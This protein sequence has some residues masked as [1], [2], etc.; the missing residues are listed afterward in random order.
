[1]QLCAKTTATTA[2]PNDPSKLD[3]KFTSAFQ[4]QFADQQR[5]REVENI[6]FFG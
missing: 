3:S 5:L 4:D 6:N 1:M 2:T